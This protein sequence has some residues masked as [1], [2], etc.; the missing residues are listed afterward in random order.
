MAVVLFRS[1]ADYLYKTLSISK[2]AVKK[3]NENKQ[4]DTLITILGRSEGNIWYSK[5]VARIYI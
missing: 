4:R 2:V 5:V 1:S 3:K